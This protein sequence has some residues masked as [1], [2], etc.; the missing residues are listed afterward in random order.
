VL[1]RDV[2]VSA[3][4]GPAVAGLWRPWIVLPRWVLDLPE[5]ELRMVI[6]HEEQHVRARDSLLLGG[7]LALAALSAWNPVTW[8]QLG[9][10]R[11]AMEMDC[12][13]RVLRRAPDRVAYGSSLL[14]VAA[15]ASGASLGLAAFT[16]RSLSLKRRILAMTAKTSRWTA[17]GGGVLVVSGVLVGLQ[18]CGVDGPLAPEVTPEAPAQTVVIPAPDVD[19]AVSLMDEPTFTPFTVAPS[20]T[21][22]DEVIAAMEAEYPPLLREA[23]VGG[24]VRVYFFIDEEG[25]VAQTRV[26]DSSGHAALDDAAL[27]VAGAFRFTPAL[28]KDKKV[29]VWVSFPITFQVR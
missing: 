9:R 2:Y 28:N 22:R 8:W 17:V 29:P 24:T 26:D 18:A 23:G 16:E 7:A 25:R 10:L 12:D 5:T 3:D 6:L 1:G 4:Q 20:I 19:P 15:R 13:R 21:N 27:R 11:A 14:A